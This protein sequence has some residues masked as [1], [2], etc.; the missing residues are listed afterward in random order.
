V[1]FSDEEI[2][3]RLPPRGFIGALVKTNATVSGGGSRMSGRNRHRLLHGRAAALGELFEMGIDQIEYAAE[4]ALE[5]YLGLTADPI[6]GWYK[7]PASSEM[8]F[9]PC[10]Q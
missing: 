4:V 10:A 5:H 8:P 7:S 9:Q 1:G 3:Q 2:C 6:C